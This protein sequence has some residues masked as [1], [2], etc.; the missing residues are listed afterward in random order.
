MHNELE[1]AL[2]ALSNSI[3]TTNPDH[4]RTLKETGLIEV[5]GAEQRGDELVIFFELTELG[6]EYHKELFQSGPNDL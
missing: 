6:E 3:C 4:A 2:P 1:A 5:T